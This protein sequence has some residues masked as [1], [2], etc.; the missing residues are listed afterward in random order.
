MH[1]FSLGKQIVAL[2]F[3]TI[4]VVV[5]TLLLFAKSSYE[6]VDRV[7]TFVSKDFKQFLGEK[8]QLSIDTLAYSLS[9]AIKNAPTDIARQQ[10][11]IDR[12]KGF[13]FERD[14]SGYYFVSKKTTLMYTGNPEYRIGVDEENLKDINGVHY[15][16]NLYT[17]AMQGGGFVDYI[18]PKPLPGGGSQDTPKISYAQ[19]IAGTDDWWV[20]AGVYMDNVAKRTYMITSEIERDVRHSF[21]IYACIVALILLIVVVPLYY[22]FYRKITGNI[23]TLNGGLNQFFSFINYESKQAPQTMILRSKDEFGQM[24]QALNTNVQKACS[25]LA[26]DQNFSEEALHILGSVRAGDLSKNIKTN[27][28]NPQLQH[29]G[30]NLNDFFAFLDRTFR[31]ICST[32]QIYSK[33][34]FTKGMDTA[35][36]QGSFLQLVNDLNTLQQ[37]IVDSLKHS[38]DFAHTLNEETKTLNQ[39]AS[40]LQDASKQ[41][42]QSLEQTTSMLEQISASMQG[43][44]AKSHEVIEQSDGIKNMVLIINEI[45]DQ[46]GLLALNAAIEAARAGEH[47]RGF[48]VV[49]DEVRKLAE[50]TQKSLREIEVSTQSLTQCINDAAN[51]IEEQTTSISKI[52]E[53]METLK[54]TTIHNAEIASTSLDISQNVAAIAQKILDEANSKKF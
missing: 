36:L 27:A 30:S 29:L 33:N 25:H 51:A 38:L 31:Q 16:K 17:K 45:A 24:A 4:L 50:R 44:N 10:I 11:V 13:R 39:T 7:N 32:I 5:A 53:A 35:T 18:A 6:S 37:S 49:A 40:N 48:A 41:Q 8:L 15:F 22:F 3:F 52:N 12:L 47:G 2:W 19:K 21:Y 34:D 28:S 42:A 43:V 54:E 14:K 26:D 23:K 1:L 9:N 46:I 20:G